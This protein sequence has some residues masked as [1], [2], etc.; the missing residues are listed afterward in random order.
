[1]EL[2]LFAA[3]IG[4]IPA[5]I[6]KTKGRSFGLWWLY[7]AALF[8]IATPH[9]LLMQPREGSEAAL[10][11]EALRRAA[12]GLMPSRPAAIDFIADGVVM[13][14]PYRREPDGIVAMVGGRTIKFRSIEDLQAMLQAG[15]PWG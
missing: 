12:K 4:L 6:A 10:K 11:D 5:Y 13:G 7:G 15:K 14:T 1:M 8:I 2:L 3:L 9:A